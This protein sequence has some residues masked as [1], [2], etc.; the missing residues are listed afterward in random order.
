MYKFLATI[1][2]SFSIN[3]SF[4][5]NFSRF[6]QFIDSLQVYNK[7]M[8]NITLRKNG[9]VLFE[10]SVGFGNISTSE[11]LSRDSKF[12]VASISKMFTAVIYFKT[13]EL[14]KLSGN[15]KL[16]EYFPSIPKSDLIT[17]D[18][19]LNHRSGIYNYTTDEKFFNY[20]T[21]PQTS[22]F[23]IN[24]IIE[25]GSQF[26]PRSD[27]WYSNS[28]FLLLTFILEK[29]NGKSLQQQI[30]EWIT[31][32]LE[33]TNTSLPGSNEHPEVNSYSYFNN[34]KITNTSDP[35]VLLGA[36]AIVSTTEDLAK[37][38]EGLFNEKLIEKKSLYKMISIE[39]GFGRGIFSFLFDEHIIFGH[40]G[41]IDGFQS[42]ISYFP[43]IGLLV[44]MLSNG[45]NY[46]YTEITD[47]MIS[48]Y[49]GDEIVIPNLKSII[50]SVEQLEKY[51]GEYRSNEISLELSFTLEDGLRI[52]YPSG[53]ESAALSPKGNH[54]FEFNAVNA[55][56][57]F[58]PEKGKM[59][60]NQ[61]GETLMFTR[62]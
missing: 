48:S 34:W 31:E 49:W 32:P 7:F 4:A 20:K 26:I 40:T 29:T 27:A 51:V 59:Q 41:G 13:L 12:R 61:G 42:S 44:C 11:E 47:A 30:R 23:L 3:H 45:M 43:E 18:N 62:R 35:S 38:V 55:K 9:E 46:N 39:D 2:L 37:F 50:I 60:L 56:I 28:N 8:G 54:T 15:Q 22:E 16:S 19:L 5:Q 25:G 21:E 10:K 1:L 17:I 57:T 6:D 58:S 33:M 52:A 14:G 24:R 53:Y 36:G